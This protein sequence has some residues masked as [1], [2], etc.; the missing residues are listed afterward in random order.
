M[1]MSNPLTPLQPA[2]VDQEQH[3]LLLRILDCPDCSSHRKKFARLEEENFSLKKEIG[4][5]QKQVF[6]LKGRLKLNT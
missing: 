3:E 5:L 4:S 1:C 2:D 6:E